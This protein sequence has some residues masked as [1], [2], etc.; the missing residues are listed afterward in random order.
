MLVMN[1]EN[2]LYFLGKKIPVLPVVGAI[3]AGIGLGWLFFF[4]RQRRKRRLASQTA[5]TAQTESK[6]LT[7]S[8]SSKELSSTPSV[9]FTRSIPSYPSSTTEFGKANTYFGVQVFS[10]A[11]LEEATENFDNSRELGDGGFGTV[12]YGMMDKR[13]YLSYKIQL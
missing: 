8:L 11:E 5:L 10:Y 13:F 2:L 6:E 7:T 9:K 3:L 12:Y 4:C 1:Q